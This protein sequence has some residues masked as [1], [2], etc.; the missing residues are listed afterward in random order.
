MRSPRCVIPA[1]VA[2][3]A[4]VVRMLVVPATMKVLG[5]RNWWIPRWHDRELSNL[6]VESEDT[7]PE[8]EPES[9]FEVAGV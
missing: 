3:D 6:G 4:T 7:G 2:I 8:P 5:D 9:E 1:A